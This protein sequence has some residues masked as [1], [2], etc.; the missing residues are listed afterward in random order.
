MHMKVLEYMWLSSKVEHKTVCVTQY[1]RALG[2]EQAEI[3]GDR[4]RE[5]TEI[6]KECKETHN[7]TIKNHNISNKLIREQNGQ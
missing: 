7:R 6:R 2:R 5:L 4:S 1:Q 3:K